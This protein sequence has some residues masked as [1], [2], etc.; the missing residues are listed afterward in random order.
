MHM[1]IS[2]NLPARV[3]RETEPFRKIP[4]RQARIPHGERAFVHGENA[5]HVE[6]VCGLLRQSHGIL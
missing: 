5:E 6:G 1:G 2:V 3:R 4:V